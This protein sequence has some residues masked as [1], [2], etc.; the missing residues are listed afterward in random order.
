[1]FS[2]RTFSF[3][4]LACALFSCKQKTPPPK[5]AATVVPVIT[6]REEKE[7]LY[8]LDKSPMDMIY[9][10]EDFPVLKMS[11]KVTG[12]PVARVIYSR[13]SKDG[14]T[15]FGNVVKYGTYWRLG[16]NEGTEIEF[17]TDVVINGRRV[18]K[19]RYIIYCIPY[20]KKWT[21]RLNDDLY[22]WGLRIHSNR[23]VYSFDI[24]VEK[25]NQSIE[26]L[27]MKFMQSATGAELVMGWDS[28][29]A[30]LPFKY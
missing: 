8:D 3:V 13:P 11:G 26:I 27:T 14:R 9:Y 23:D 19:G 17:F 22:A 15:I 24:P 2:S 16:A 30:S 21:I 4:L 28:A 6:S 1:M 25:L 12:L 18:K 20:E 5:T 29:K 10:P 7:R